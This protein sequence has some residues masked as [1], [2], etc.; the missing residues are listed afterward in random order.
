MYYDVLNNIA[1]KT[2]LSEANKCSETDLAIK[3]LD[4]FG[5]ND[6]LIY[7]RAYAG[8]PFLVTLNK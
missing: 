8:Y 5:S 3:S 4:S 7:D 2:V 6:L 1:I